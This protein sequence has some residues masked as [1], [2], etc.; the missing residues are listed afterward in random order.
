MSPSI[1]QIIKK[2]HKI[3]VLEAYHNNNIL[4]IMCQLKFL[5]G[6]NR[7]KQSLT[8]ILIVQYIAITYNVVC[9]DKNI[10]LIIKC[11]KI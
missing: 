10:R 4:N 8:I 9:T 2:L 7:N 3:N 1:V 5:Q 11:Y 6:T